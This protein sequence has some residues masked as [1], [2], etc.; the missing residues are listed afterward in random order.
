MTYFCSMF[1]Q[2]LRLCDVCQVVI[3]LQIYLRAK[4]YNQYK[5]RY[6]H[7]LT[8]YVKYIFNLGT[9]MLVQVRTGLDDRHTFFRDSFFHP[10]LK[11]IY[12]C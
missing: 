6:D 11:S 10:Y 2:Y 5:L 9:R 1:G 7:M 8:S 4:T 3:F 12:T